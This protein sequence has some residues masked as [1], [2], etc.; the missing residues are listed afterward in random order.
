MAGSIL[1]VLFFCLFLTGDVLP[2]TKY[3]KASWDCYKKLYLVFVR[4]KNASDLYKEKFILG[5]A[6]RLLNNSLRLLGLLSVLISL[7]LFILFSISFLYW[8]NAYLF[9]YMFTW[10]VFWLSVF[11]FIVYFIVKKIYEQ[12]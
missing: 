7:F 6:I 12:I 4:Y 9:Q 5:Y 11:T 3:T 2:F 8:R 10:R 1:F